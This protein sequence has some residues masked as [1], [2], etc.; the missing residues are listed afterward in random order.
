MVSDFTLATVDSTELSLHSDGN[1]LSFL[2]FIPSQIIGKAQGKIKAFPDFQW[3]KK[4]TTQ[5]SIWKYYLRV[6]PEIKGFSK[7]SNKMHQ[8]E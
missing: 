8:K 5:Q 7:Y 4:Y 2:N 1:W 3:C 6:A